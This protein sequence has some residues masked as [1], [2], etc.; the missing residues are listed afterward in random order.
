MIK[1]YEDR[2]LNLKKDTA[3]SHAEKN[4]VMIK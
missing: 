1:N 3:T 2:I 4:E